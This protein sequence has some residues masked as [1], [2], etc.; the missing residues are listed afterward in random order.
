MSKIISIHSFHRGTG[1]TTI[2]ANLAVLLAVGGY[3]VC[4]L[5]ADVHLPGL[6]ILF[7][8]KDE[9]IRYSLQ[10][11]VEGRCRFEQTVYDVTPRLNVDVAGRLF[12]VSD[13]AT[14]DMEDLLRLLRQSYTDALMDGCNTA[15]EHLNLDF[16]LVDVR[17]GITEETIAPI[18]ISDLLY[19]ILRLDEQD[20]HGTG[21]MVELAQRL[22]APQVRLIVN[23]VVSSMDFAAIKADAEQTFQCSVAAVLPHAEKLM[24]LA[25]VGIFALKY[26]KHPLSLKLQQVAKLSLS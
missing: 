22:H 19:L 11:Y 18:A 2:A 23:E 6:H 7:G 4:L 26:P 14:V 21:L 5:D 9:E 25:G 10:D 12:L 17:A 24:G 15:I 8:L 16:L 20:Y 3:R 13:L 1:K